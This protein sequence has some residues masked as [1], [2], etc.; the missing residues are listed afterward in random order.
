MSTQVN[1]TGE[2]PTIQDPYLTDMLLLAD[3]VWKLLESPGE[4]FNLFNFHDQ[5]CRKGAIEQNRADLIGRILKHA[6]DALVIANTKRTPSPQESI[7]ASPE[8][9]DDEFDLLAGDWLGLYFL[10]MG[11]PNIWEPIAFFAE[12]SGFP[13][14]A[15]LCKAVGDVYREARLSCVRRP[16]ASHRV[17][18]LDHNPLAIFAMEAT[19]REK[20]DLKTAVALLGMLFELLQLRLYLL[21]GGSL[22]LCVPEASLK[23]ALKIEIARAENLHANGIRPRGGGV[24]NPTVVVDD[25]ASFMW[26][27]LQTGFLTSRRNDQVV[28]IGAPD[29]EELS[30]M[31]GCVISNTQ[32]IFRTRVNNISSIKRQPGTFDQSRVATNARETERGVGSNPGR[33]GNYLPSR[34]LNSFRDK[35][36]RVTKQQLDLSGDASFLEERCQALVR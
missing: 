27:Q 31:P 29:D 11:F 14:G 21:A 15:S 13:R 4:P 6:D 36:E 24:F 2:P 33:A 3:N 7:H 17:L 23:S 32:G 12:G 22:S 19:F 20:R 26:R 25:M 16:L 28:Y 1:L 8:L 34:M 18:V 35:L 5:F 30:F 10:G 9:S